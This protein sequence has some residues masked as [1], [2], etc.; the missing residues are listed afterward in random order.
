MKKI[1]FGISFV[2]SFL[3]VF[4]AFGCG[5][6]ND[7]SPNQGGHI[8]SVNRLDGTI[9]VGRF[10]TQADS[11]SK[12]TINSSASR[13]P[14]FGGFAPSF[15][16]L[17]FPIGNIKTTEK[18]SSL[19]INM[20]KKKCSEEIEYELV[21]I[22]ELLVPQEDYKK[23]EDCY[24]TTYPHGDPARAIY[25]PPGCTPL[26]KYETSKVHSFQLKKD[27]DKSN[28]NGGWWSVNTPEFLD[29]VNNSDKKLLS[30]KVE[31]CCYGANR[32]P[33][34]HQVA[35]E[36]GGNNGGTGNIPTLE[37]TNK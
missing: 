20:I 19:K 37:I 31:Y 6:G 16:I 2:M 25:D 26:P 12:E 21:A 24:T 35:F 10:N 29:F 15:G 13:A 23:W 11:L 9:S 33:L 4:L 3:V 32:K 28:P 34:S 14:T 22:T 7:S 18:I 5:K 8:Y 30:F 17:T 1:I 36:D 27:D